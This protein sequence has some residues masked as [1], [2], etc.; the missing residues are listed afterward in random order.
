[1]T[2]LY[3]AELVPVPTLREASG[4]LDIV[5]VVTPFGTAVTSRRRAARPPRDHH[6]R[7]AGTGAARAVPRLCGVG[8]DHLTRS[9]STVG[10][11]HRGT[12]RSR[13][14]PDGPVP[15]LRHG[16]SLA[17]R[18]GAHRTGSP[19]RHITD[20]APARASRRVDAG[21]A[22]H[23]ARGAAE[24]R[25]WRTR[26]SP[27]RPHRRYGRRVADAADARPADDA[28]HGGPV[29]QPAS[30][31]AGRRR[32]SGDDRGCGAPRGH[33][34][35][36]RRHADAG[37]ADGP[38]DDRRPDIHHVWLQR[39]VSRSTDKGRAE[40]DRHGHVHEQPRHADRGPLARSA[41]RQP[42]RRRARGHAGAGRAGPDLHLHPALPGRRHLLVPPARPRRHPA[43][44]RPLRQH[45]RRSGRPGLLRPGE[46]RGDLD[47]RRLPDGRRRAVPLWPRTHRPTRSWDDSATSFW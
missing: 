20:G 24:R 35:E 31:P 36:V 3:C 41:A 4:R 22:R 26:R 19:A 27:P 30:V 42:V 47:P 28:R 23:A 14:D 12:I 18:E 46:P 5:P 33:Q 10:D 37:R 11:C 38:A 39:T 1:M 40:L 43:G 7:T 8:R 45:P 21:R 2:S 15:P 17:R 44:P 29:A 32:G 16:G 34:P 25:G 13:R 9:R 6:R